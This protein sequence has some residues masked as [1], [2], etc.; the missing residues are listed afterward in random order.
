MCNFNVWPTKIHFGQSNLLYIYNGMEIN[1]LQNV[2]SSKNGQPIS[3]PYVTMYHT[4]S[5][6][7]IASRL[8]TASYVL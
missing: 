7:Y 8:R 5:Y 1:N 2:Q 3:E 4:Y 6:I